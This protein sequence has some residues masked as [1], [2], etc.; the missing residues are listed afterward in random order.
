MDQVPGPERV[1]RPL[2][3][4]QAGSAETQVLVDE[5]DQLGVRLLVAM[6]PGLEQIGD[7]PRLGC[8][9]PPSK[10]KLNLG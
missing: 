10:P 9:Q 3:P 6:A 7:G 5:G 2:A 4:E 1:A 8:A